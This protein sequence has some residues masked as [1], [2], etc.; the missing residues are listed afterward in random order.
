MYTSENP[1]TMKTIL[2]IAAIV[3]LYSCTARRELQ[4]DIV[5]AELIKID[6]VYRYASN[7]QRQL[8]WRDDY[9]IEYVTYA[10]LSTTYALGTRMM[11]LVKR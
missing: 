4:A 1:S 5:N 8:T 10:A 3:A 2:V 7:P 9:D 11:V 6:T